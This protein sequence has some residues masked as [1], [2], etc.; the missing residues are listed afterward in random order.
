MTD[1]PSH[2]RMW[3]QEMFL[4]FFLNSGSN[5]GWS[6]GEGRKV[7]HGGELRWKCMCPRCLATPVSLTEMEKMWDDS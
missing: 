5:R 7:P 4:F 3:Q 2:Y 1:L 6:S